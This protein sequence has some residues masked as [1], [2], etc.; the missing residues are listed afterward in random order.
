[1]RKYRI[2]MLLGNKTIDYPHS[3]HMG[4]ANTLEEEGHIVVAIADLIPYHTRF[5]AEENLR[6]AFEIAARIDLD[7]LVVPAG[8]VTGYLSGNEA[9][10]MRLMATLDREKTLVLERELPGYRCIT[11]DNEPGMRA[12]MKHLIEDRGLKKIAFISGP[13]ASKGSIEREGVYFEEMKAHGLPVSDSMFARGLFSGECEDVVEQILED[14]PDIEAIACACDMIAYNTYEI[15]RR[16]KI[17]IGSGVA[18]TGFD[19]HPKSAHMDPPLS[20][21]H[22]TGYDLGCL[23]AREAIRICEG[24][25]QEYK[26]ISSTFIAR[27]SCGEDMKGGVEYFRQILRQKPFPADKVI[28]I[29]MSATISMAGP[30]VM[31]DFRSRMAAFFEKIRTAYLKHR[32]EKAPDVLLFSSGDL[33][34]LFGAEYQQYLS[35]EGFHSVA[36]TLLEAL[37]EELPP[38]EAN[39]VI[40]QISHLHL[41]I[42]RMTEDN[43]A[44]EVLVNN[45]REWDTFHM[46]DDALREYQSREVV[47]EHILN[48]FIKLGVNHAELFLFPESVTLIGA[49]SFAISDHVLHIGF[50]K[51]GKVTM[52]GEREV[53]LDRLLANVSVRN[54]DALSYTVCGLMAGRELLGLAVLNAGRLDSNGQLMAF[55]NIGFALKHLQ[56]MAV[57][58]EVNGILRENNLILARQS[59][60]DDMTGLLN[61]RGFMERI[62]AALTTPGSGSGAIVFFD[63]DGLKAINDTYGHDA[64]D[65]AIIATSKV[66]ADVLSFGGFVGRLGGDEF[67]AFLSIDSEGGIERAGNEVR[68]RLEE[69][70]AKDRRPYTLSISYGGNFFTIDDDSVNNINS[71]MI[72]ADDRL[73]EMKRAKKGDERFEADK[74]R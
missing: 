58:R 4:F 19:D 18:V 17:D 49:K 8:V 15:L 63:L 56:M 31:R 26:V 62:S 37:M 39:W 46:A 22:M 47:Y 57:E 12:C 50:M 73:Y 59:M 43:I 16:H 28:D 54:Q 20:T 23:A 51:D 45:K 38:E 40:E 1:M 10:T 72:S 42:A 7:A 65:E 30:K 35:L 44:R 13:A 24:R 70:N 2:G 34:E 55:L 66:L 32:D 27:N 21:V 11:K 41:R 67:I 52:T 3:I 74:L 53:D 71:L 61:R 6:I 60:M 64:G 48:D 29:M 68:S 36:I 33:S 9:E 69:I 5:N 25:P 14:N